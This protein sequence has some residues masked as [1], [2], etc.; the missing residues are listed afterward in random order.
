[1]AFV[2][3]DDSTTEKGRAAED[4]AERHLRALGYDI[5]ERNARSPL[6]EL[7]IVATDGGDLVFVEVRSRELDDAGRAEE[8]VGL[9]KQRRLTRVAAAFLE[10]RGLRPATCRFDV[11]AINGEELTLYRDAFRPGLEHI[12]RIG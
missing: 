6:G 2:P 5:L 12:G 4:R 11:I 10:D 3:G 1:M 7:D 9:A 8:T